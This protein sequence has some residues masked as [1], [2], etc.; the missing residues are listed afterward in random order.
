MLEIYPPEVV[1]CERY[2]GRLAADIYKQD[3][4]CSRYARRNYTLHVY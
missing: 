3:S 2:E 4:I 1:L